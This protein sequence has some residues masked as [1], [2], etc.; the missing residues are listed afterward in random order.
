MLFSAINP[1]FSRTEYDFSFAAQFFR[2]ELEPS[3]PFAGWGTPFY[4]YQE[5]CIALPRLALRL[6]QERLAYRLALKYVC[7]FFPSPKVPLS[8][9]PSLPKV[10]NVYGF[11]LR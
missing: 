3:S 1:I 2:P 6:V 7:G 5:A 8:E 9:N 4:L 10:Q 11:G